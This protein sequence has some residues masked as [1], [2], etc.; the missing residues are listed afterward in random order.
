MTAVA[1]A[2]AACTSTPLQP[3]A[4]PVTPPASR[5]TPATPIT[6]ALPPTSTSTTP[7]TPEA[8]PAALRM[9][10]AS[11]EALPGWQKDDLRAA[12]PAFMASCGVLVKRAEWKESCTIARS[13]NGN[14]DRAIRSF[15]EAFMTPSQV[16]APDGASD[17]LVTGYY[18]PL[19]RG[20]RKRGGAYQTPLY[21]VPDDLITVD[22]A[23]VYPELKSMRLRGKLV[24]KKVVPY[25]TRADI[26]RAETTGKELL[27]VDDPV[28]SFFL[29]VQGSGRVQLTDTQETVRVAYADQNGHPYKSIGRYLVDQGE[30]TFEQASAQGIKAWVAGHPTRMQELFNVNPSY[31]FF[32]EERLPDPKVGPKGALGVPL[33]PQRSIAIDASQLPLGV[34]VF[35]ATT[36]PNSDIPLQRLV[37]A[38]DT[39][40]A[41]RGAIRVDY[42]FGFGTEASENAGRMKQRGS[43]WVL[44]PKQVPAP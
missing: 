34:P 38:Q 19:L 4:K 32:K 10:P 35:L 31:V 22:L 16:I 14:D 13:V 37:M 3:P 15:F 8:K 17:G 33:T 18:E 25:A 9:V 11:F 2:L 24:G 40:G 6:P 36:Q 7:A 21:K 12:W 30:L 23:S 29:Q 28:E 39:G 5:P 20:A 41:I 26:E 42:F 27:W 43:V 1:L 44:L